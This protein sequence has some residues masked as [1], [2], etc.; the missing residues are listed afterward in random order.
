M[1][2]EDHLWAW[3]FDEND[4]A[5][6]LDGSEKGKDEGEVSDDEDDKDVQADEEEYEEYEKYEE[7]EEYEGEE[8]KQTREGDEEEEEEEEE[9]RKE[10]KRRRERRRR[11]EE[12]EEEEEEYEGDEEKQTR[13]ETQKHEAL[14]RYQSERE[15]RRGR[16]QHAQLGEQEARDELEDPPLEPKRR[17][18]K[19]PR[20]ITL[21]ASLLLP[22]RKD[23]S[24]SQPT[25]G[26]T[27]SKFLASDATHQAKVTGSSKGKKTLSVRAHDPK[28]Q[29]VQE[30]EEE[31]NND[32]NIEADVDMDE[33]QESDDSNTRS[34]PGP[35]PEHYRR[36]AFEAANLY[37]ETLKKIARK[38]GKPVH[39]FYRLVGQ[40]RWMPRGPNYW[41]MV[42]QYITDPEGGNETK[43]EDTEE[44]EIAWKQRRWEEMRK[45]ALG[46]H[47]Q[48]KK[49]VQE[50]FAWLREWFE[51]RYQENAQPTIMKGLSQRG[52]R[53]I[54]DD[55]VTLADHAAKNRGVCC[56]GYVLD[57]HG[58][59][60]IMW[61]AGSIYERMREMYDTQIDQ[62]IKDLVAQAHGAYMKERDGDSSVDADYWNFLSRLVE[63]PLRSKR[64]AHRKFIAEYLRYSLSL[65]H[66]IRIENWSDVIP[67]PG[68]GLKTLKGDAYTM[69]LYNLSEYALKKCQWEKS[70]LDREG[71]SDDEEL[72]VKTNEKVLRIVAWTDAQKALTLDQQGDVPLVVSVSGR[73]LCTG[74]NSSTW[75]A[76]GAT[77][78]G[79]AKSK[80]TAKT[81][82]D[83]KFTRD[84][85]RSRS[86][87]HSRSPSL[88]PSRLPSPTL[89]FARS[90]SYSPSRGRSPVRDPSPSAILPLSVIVPP[91]MVVPDLHMTN[92]AKRS[93]PLHRPVIMSIIALPIPILRD[94][95]GLARRL[96]STGM[97]RTFTRIYQSHLAG[98]SPPPDIYETLPKPPR[99]REPSP[100]FDQGD[101]EFSV[102]HEPPR[103]T[104]RKP[105]ATRDT[106]RDVEV[107]RKRVRDNWEKEADREDKRPTKKKRVEFVG[108]INDVRPSD[109]RGGN[110]WK[111]KEKES[112]HKRGRE[113]YRERK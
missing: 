52:V 110:R 2:L 64:D 71:G 91:F 74:K 92:A 37:D 47:W 3:S 30:W 50:K 44:T 83:T 102:V 6:L 48:D 63:I 18:G 60:S 13:E 12:E 36:Q 15:E 41:N 70:M 67:P 24:S 42:Q 1:L 111:G 32:V 27:T 86:R 11:E 81:R 99:R 17:Y 9:E 97:T 20:E 73:T 28:T 112:V 79:K 94:H 98:E 61:G 19:T 65:S 22:K 107:H 7:Y 35:I 5:G 54:A 85:S 46:V 95:P 16:R 53:R 57:Y 76:S 21:I 43:P 72:D 84:R 14:R 33:E 26:K 58:N 96:L 77:A 75:R 103:G 4:Y 66:Q 10:E 45:T 78:K 88:P 29:D 23:T 89:Q 100:V 82:R 51:S 8:E 49:Q 34:K 31:D 87:S 56:L 59:H 25:T 101:D 105:Q 39:A 62:Q 93:I 38:A 80:A 69:E 90:T 108:A 40:R 104:S 106:G 109:Q 113:D 55:F 68:N